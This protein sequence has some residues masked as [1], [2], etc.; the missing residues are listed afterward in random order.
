MT[1]VPPPPADPDPVEPV[2]LHE[3]R[4]RAESFGGES[5][6]YERTRPGYPDELIRDLMA[7]NPA[8][9]LDVGCGTGK[10]GRLLVDR[11]CEVLGV[12]PDPRMARIA[13]RFGMPVEVETFE[14]WPPQGRT[15]DL[16]I[17]AQAWHWV[18]PARGPIKARSVLRPS[19]R[20]AVFWNIYGHE[21]DMRAALDE[22]YARLVPEFEGKDSLALGRDSDKAGRAHLA[23]IGASGLFEPPEH[24]EYESA[25]QHTTEEWLDG[26]PT[27]SDHAQLP[28]KRLDTL[29]DAVREV[30]DER[31]GVIKVRYAT[32]LVSARVR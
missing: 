31:G 28:T 2:R 30:I 25:R 10:A 8:T 9:V 29:L 32:H 16:V 5:E 13:G 15:F 24:H 20:L 26:L 3:D 21:P 23:A 18:D 4:R 6:R 12:E 1:A 14:Q 27:F 11:G 22:V 17:S 19:G 7:A